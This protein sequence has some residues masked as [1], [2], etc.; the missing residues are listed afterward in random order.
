MYGGRRVL[1]VRVLL[2]LGKLSRAKRDPPTIAHLWVAGPT[3]RGHEPLRSPCWARRHRSQP[4]AWSHRH[5]EGYGGLSDSWHHPAE[6]VG[7]KP[8]SQEQPV[9]TFLPRVGTERE[10]GV[11]GALPAA[12]RGWLLPAQGTLPWLPP[13]ES[14]LQQWWSLGLAQGV[15]ELGNG[16]QGCFPGW[17]GPPAM[18]VG[19]PCS[20]C[21]TGM[22]RGVCQLQWGAG[23]K[24]G[25][26]KEEDRAPC[27]VTVLGASLPWS[28][29]GATCNGHSSQ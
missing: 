14:C 23:R 18:D 9:S 25:E 13:G 21:P 26:C 20:R 3:W 22:E 16:V 7:S 12:G 24:G 29:H 19:D 1:T 2:E 5:C 15:H 11:S 17:G 10:E 28:W 8:Q 27:L 4:A 6:P